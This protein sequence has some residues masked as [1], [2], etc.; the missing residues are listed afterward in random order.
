[1]A[2]ITIKHYLNTNLKSKIENGIEV[3]P[4]YVQVIYNRSVLKFKSDNAFFEYLNQDLLDSEAVKLFLSSEIKNIERCV[5]LVSLNAP[6]LLTSKDIY[7]LSKPL[8][9]LIEDNFK[10]LIKIEIPDSPKVLTELSYTSLNELLFF[11]DGYFK[12]DEA[13]EKVK[14]VRTAINCLGY[15]RLKDY[16]INYIVADLYFGENYKEI[17]ENIFS[18]S[19][20]EKRTEMLVKDFRYFAEL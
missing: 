1:M 3:F 10:K 13:S 4:V 19:F 7:R 14:N 11:L 8:H 2:K 6:E 16:N 15:F 5:N 20:D 17:Y 12:L 9:H 18:E